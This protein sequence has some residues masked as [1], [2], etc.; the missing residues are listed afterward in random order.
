MRGDVFGVGMLIKFSNNRKTCEVLLLLSPEGVSPRPIVY[1]SP[2]NYP[3]G[4]V[5]T[6]GYK[7]ILAVVETRLRGR[8]VQ[9]PAC[10]HARIWII[11]YRQSKPCRIQCSE[12][13][14]HHHDL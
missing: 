6:P 9:M 14:P 8:R 5:S 4:R 10:L 12:N 3:V 2:L 1:L 13:L 11:F 7:E